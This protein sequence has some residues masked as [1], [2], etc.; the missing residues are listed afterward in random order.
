M[1]SNL[2]SAGS[3]I[4]GGQIL[5]LAIAGPKRSAAAPSLP[6]IAEAGVPGYAFEGWFGIVVPMK[7]PDPIVERLH[8]AFSKVLAMPEVR[9]QLLT[10]GGMEAAGGSSAEFAAML[11]KERGVWSQ[12]IKQ[13][14]IKR[15]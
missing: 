10:Q 2:L 6:T 5:A 7:T 15:Q 4:K 13:E 1:F 8:Q 14:N 11:A 12:L 3:L 9:Q